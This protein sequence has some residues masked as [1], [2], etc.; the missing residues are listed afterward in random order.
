MRDALRNHGSARLCFRGLGCLG[1]LTGFAKATRR[2]LWS[3]AIVTT[4]LIA[5]ASCTSS[6]TSHAPQQ[7]KAEKNAVASANQVAARVRIDA[8]TAAAS[9][10]QLRVE[11]SLNRLERIENTRDIKRITQDDTEHPHKA[12]RRAAMRALARAR[13]GAATERLVAGLADEDEQVA[14]WA[15]FGLGLLCSNDRETITKRL[16]ARGASWYVNASE[17]TLTLEEI[18]NATGVPGKDA[19]PSD[20]TAATLSTVSPTTVTEPRLSMWTSLSQGLARCATPRAQ[21]T[22]VSW[23]SGPEPRRIDAS[24][25]VRSIVAH[26]RRIDESLAVDLLRASEGEASNQPLPQALSAFAGVINVPVS[27]QQR[28]LSSA[29]ER[30][31]HPE[32]GRV[33][34]IG[35]MSS[36]G[37]KSVSTLGSVI[38]AGDNYTPQEMAQAVR[39]LG[40]IATRQARH[41]LLRAID[42]L[43]P[44]EPVASSKSLMNARFGVLL[45]AIEQVDG[46]G[47]LARS[48]EPLAQSLVKL[49]KL[50][51]STDTSPA[52]KRRVMLLRCSAATILAGSRYNE[53]AL[54]GC[55]EL[56]SDTGRLARLTV[57]GR[58]N[59]KGKRAEAFKSYLS[60]GLSPR[61]RSTALRILTY[62]REFEETRQ[63]VTD[64][65][66]DSHPDVVTEAALQLVTHSQRFQAASNGNQQDTQVA[67]ALEQAVKRPWPEDRIDV[68][69]ALMKAA[70]ILKSQPLRLWIES[71]C[72][73]DNETVRHHA[74]EVLRER[75]G[76]SSP[77]DSVPQ[78]QPA[79]A[80]ELDKLVTSQQTIVLD[81]DVGLLRL[82][83]NPAI[84]PVAVTRVTELVREGF[85]N[86]LT[87]HRVEPG[88]VVQFGELSDV[89]GKLAPY[90]S[91][92]ALRCELTPNTFDRFSVGLAR[93]ERDTG[94][95]QVF[96][97]LS[98][99]P[100]LDGEYTWLGT[101]SGPWDM[102]AP[103]D[104][105]HNATV[106]RP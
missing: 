97:T 8:T 35:A 87:M 42:T 18:E 74:I 91:R 59:L 57:L 51:A 21:A 5:G 83:L 58:G 54:V 29:T 30:L 43:A 64:A 100:H 106:L 76:V 3:L 94:S 55:D 71:L 26:D 85:Y 37:D 62:H 101:A 63:A 79:A 33:F 15:A 6:P 31:S 47:P 52:V 96:V 82:D 27:L 75:F 50:T 86:G 90:P 4:T 80:Q 89:S 19:A 38:R 7:T 78:V 16:V 60:D 104:R 53:E 81:S 28:L 9:Q 34:A 73:A 46:M 48:A 84:A 23:L 25:A 103:G 20:A 45:T 11:L 44:K 105:I 70:G 93:G 67:R 39:A 36:L 12:V 24:F 1:C 72:A 22:L 41:E 92:K 40:L 65:L 77:C 95:T 32:P 49:A 68:K 56:E 98:R 61:V 13:S 10:L 2:C 17:P 99:A 88:F 14:S 69:I 66:R 102:L